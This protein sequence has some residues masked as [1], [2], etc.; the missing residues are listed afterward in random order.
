MFEHIN[1]NAT[2]LPN[3]EFARQA[4]I[5]GRALD[6]TPSKSLDMRK[7]VS[8]QQQDALHRIRAVLNML[9][10]EV[11]LPESAIVPNPDIVITGKG[12]YVLR[13]AETILTKHGYVRDNTRSGIEELKLL[14]MA[15]E[16]METNGIQAA[17][18][19]ANYNM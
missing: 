2:I 19:Q 3:P 9:P 7:T 4:G 13:Q 8:E 6:A 15:R 11:R 12:D 14:S 5:L 16:T 1:R 10:V 18:F 17:V